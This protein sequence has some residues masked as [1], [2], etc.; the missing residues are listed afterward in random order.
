VGQYHLSSALRRYYLNDYNG[1]EI[2][3]MPFSDL[4]DLTEDDAEVVAA[5]PENG[6][7]KVK[8]SFIDTPGLD[9]S[10]GNDMAIMA[11][12]VGRVGELDH[13]NAVIYV[14]NMSRPFGASFLRFFDYI[15]RSM[16]TLAQGLIIVHSGYTVEKVDEFLS[17]KK[18][19][20]KLR[21]EAFVKA[22]NSKVD[23][24]H[25]FMDN[26]PDET[27]PFAIT[28]SFNAIFRLLTLLSVQKPLPTSGLKLLKTPNMW[29]VDVHILYSLEQLHNHLKDAWNDEVTR[30]SKANAQIM[31]TSREIQRLAS[32][33]SAFQEQL[34]EIDNNSSINLGTKTTSKDYSFFKN[35]LVKGDLWLDDEMVTFDADCPISN[36]EKTATGG[37]KWLK[38]DLRGTSWRATL[39]AGAFRSI[40][41]SATLYTTSRL[42]HRRE[43][44]MLKDSI[45]DTSRSKEFHEETLR[46][47]GTGDMDMKAEKLGQDVERC[48]G[49]IEVIK[50]ETFDVGLWPILKRFYVSH[51]QLTRDHIRD[52]VEVYDR[53]I[54]ELL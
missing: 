38:E 19:L 50:R 20:S 48:A 4:V 47:S 6:G 27:S 32:K 31:K 26:N 7:K 10:D 1:R 46:E 51:G 9:D 18:D 43:I 45:I 54:A 13:L 42:K 22:T 14:R 3:N 24:S 33:L 34:D 11:D 35:F 12:I 41:G 30:V 49:L 25:F 29:N 21:R 40:N 36:V 52:F 17:Q 44:E 15:Q 8:F 16:P 28:E 37:S 5:E 53:E 23:L 2:K 39:T